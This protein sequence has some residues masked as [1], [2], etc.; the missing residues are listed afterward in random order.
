LID[1][2]IYIADIANNGNKYTTWIPRQ[3]IPEVPNKISSISVTPESSERNSSPA[4]IPSTAGKLA[5]YAP[6]TNGTNAAGSSAMVKINALG[7]L[8]VFVGAA[9]TLL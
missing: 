3:V 9:F 2:A 8:L 1:S 6:G 4:Q 5:D 7:A